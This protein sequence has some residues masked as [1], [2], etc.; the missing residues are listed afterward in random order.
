[1]RKKASRMTICPK[2][3][4]RPWRR[5]DRGHLPTRAVH[6]N[7][8]KCQQ[9]ILI[10]TEYVCL[11]ARVGKKRALIRASLERW[12]RKNET[13]LN[14]NGRGL[15]R[16]KVQCNGNNWST[17]DTLRPFFFASASLFSVYFGSPTGRP[18]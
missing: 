3:S 1:M 18:P 17:P 8:V 7:G 4:E 5:N 2:R 14:R 15:E 11:C 16:C 9:N 12:P 13:V 6:P 10:D